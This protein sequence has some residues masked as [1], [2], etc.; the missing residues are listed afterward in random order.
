[1][2]NESRVERTGDVTYTLRVLEAL[3]VP[4]RD[5]RDVFVQAFDEVHDL[6]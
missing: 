6:A 5:D 2:A 4:V 3:A 1:M